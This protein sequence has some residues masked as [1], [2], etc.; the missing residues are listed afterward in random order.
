MI[1]SSR[2]IE[3][4]CVLTTSECCLLAV[5]PTHSIMTEFIEKTSV[6]K[7]NWPRIVWPLFDIS[8]LTFGFNLDEA[9]Q[10]AGCTHRLILFGLSI[11]DDDGCTGDDGDSPPLEK[12]EAA[13]DEASKMEE[14]IEARVSDI[15]TSPNFCAHQGC[16][17]THQPDARKKRTPIDIRTDQQQYTRTGGSSHSA[18]QTATYMTFREFAEVDSDIP[19]THPRGANNTK[20][21]RFG[22][23]IPLQCEQCGSLVLRMVVCAVSVDCGVSWPISLCF[24]RYHTEFHSLADREQIGLSRK[25]QD[26]KSEIEDKHRKSAESQDGVI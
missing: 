10:F 25:E 7:S 19:C 6:D 5:D 14:V 3:S 11:H 8:L 20:R 17:H 18:R 1:A 13:A 23:L 26:H 15:C 24:L 2:I 12:V 21:T 16:L 22:A 9:T 4:P